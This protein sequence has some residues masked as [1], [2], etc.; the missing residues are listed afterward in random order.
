MAKVESDFGVGQYRLLRQE[1][2]QENVVW[3]S[4]PF[5]PFHAHDDP[6]R[7]APEGL[8][9]GRDLGLGQLRGDEAHAQ[10]KHHHALALI[11]LYE[12]EYVLQNAR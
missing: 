11:A 4:N 12:V 3:H 9:E 5:W 7:E 8:E 1:L 2:P 6:L 10:G